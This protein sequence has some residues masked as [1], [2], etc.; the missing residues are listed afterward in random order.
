MTQGEVRELV[1]NALAQHRAAAYPTPPHGHHPNFVGA[2][3]AAERLMGLRL[4]Q[5]ATVILAG[6]DQVLKPL[7]EAALK[8]GKIVL[9]PHPDKAG[10]Y[11]SLEGLLPHQ[12]KRVREVAQLG[13]PIEL[14]DTTIDLVLV[15]SVAVDEARNWLGK[16]YGF[17]YKDLQVAAPWATLAHTLMIF[18]ELPCQPERRVDLIAT[19]HQIIGV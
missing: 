7:R 15:G 14:K 10:R 4:W 8:S 9:M 13:K 12:L 16:G 6:P 3:R 1:W 11:L 5:L 19:P 2:S 18:D 17:P